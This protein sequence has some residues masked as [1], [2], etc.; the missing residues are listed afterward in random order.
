ME[1]DA[2]LFLPGHVFSPSPALGAAICKEQELAP[3][4]H[5]VW[6]A[7][8]LTENASLVLEGDLV[9]TVQAILK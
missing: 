8:V 3:H 6:D 1:E 2:E 4:Q 7:L 5:S 9:L